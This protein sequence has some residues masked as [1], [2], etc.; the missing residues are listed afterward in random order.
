[1]HTGLLPLHAIGY[2]VTTLGAE[3][4]KKKRKPSRI[5]SMVAG[6]GLERL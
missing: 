5:S 6:G 4:D 2:A 1:M 3:K